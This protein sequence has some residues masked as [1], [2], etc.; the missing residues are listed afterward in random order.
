MTVELVLVLPIVLLLLFALVELSML[1]R[2][3]QTLIVAARDGARVATLS[4]ATAEQVRR[5]V[6]R[7]L[8]GRMAAE[9]QIQVQMAERSGEPT[10]VE[11]RVPMHAAA[12][13]L[14]RLIG[15]GVSD[16]YLVARTTMCRE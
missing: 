6:R 11:V 1:A 4:G 15:F 16:R 14:L 7:H 13:D 10:M 8:R 9:A 12:P 5:A 2:A 3:Q